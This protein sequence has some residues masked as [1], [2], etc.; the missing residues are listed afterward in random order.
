MKPIF[1][2]A[3]ALALTACNREQTKVVAAPPAP[4]PQAP[5]AQPG[6]PSGPPPLTPQ[7][8]GPITMEMTHDQAVAALGKV[9]ADASTRDQDWLACHMIRPESPDG[10]WIMVE[11]DRV[12]RVSVEPQATG[13][14][15]DRGVKV[16]DTAAA[17]KAAYPTGLIE[18]PHKYEAA[19]A[20]YLTWWAKPGVAG[21][22]Y[23]I[24]SDGKVA[25]IAAGTPSIEYVEGCS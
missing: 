5:A 2:I 17:V 13:V 21:I 1:A 15:S 10:V 7:G 12:T 14:A 19:P 8:W 18:T 9:K 22:R 3:V 25:S 16:G 20:A 24:G 23:S 6:T 11:E 4:A